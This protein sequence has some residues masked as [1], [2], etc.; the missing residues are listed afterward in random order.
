MKV[1]KK[2][3][4]NVVIC[5]DHNNRELVAF[6]RGIGFPAAPYELDDLSKID[7]TYYGVNSSYMGLVNEIPEEVFEVAAKIV[8]MAVNYI[9]CELS[10][11]LVF[12]LADHINFAIERNQRNMNL[13]NPFLYDI[14][15][16]YEKEMDIGNLAVKMIRRYL[17]VSLP[18]EEAGNIALHFINAEALSEKE[19]EFN[20][21]DTVVEEVTYLI[22]KELN[23]RIKREDF[24]YSRFVS[25]LQYLMKRKDAVSSISSDNIKL[26]MEMKEEFPVIYQC[27][28]KIRDYM[29]GKLDWELSEEELLYLI[30]HV[31]RLYAREDCNR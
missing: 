24:N 13:R 30:L 5:L 22:E 15:Y 27:V 6:G 3:N 8:D 10:S 20:V 16:F 9:D 21:S 18:E 2:I 7:R 29:A 25:H 31:N 12:T 19:N 17:K 4:N 28:L 11:N 1:I 26:Y 14:R 23:I